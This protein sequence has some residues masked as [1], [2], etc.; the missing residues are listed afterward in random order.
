MK[1]V[2]G[3]GSFGV[4]TYAEY[5]DENSENNINGFYA[6]KSISKADVVD[7]GQISLLC[8]LSYI[9][10]PPPHPNFPPSSLPYPLLTTSPAKFSCCIF[11]TPIVFPYFLSNIIFPTLPSHS[12]QLR[13]VIDE[14]K[15]LAVMNSRFVL[16]LYGKTLTHTHTRT[17]K[18][19]HLHTYTYTHKFYSNLFRL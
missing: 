9:S 7:T 10:P 13:H 15:L 12:G 2:L 4:V 18:C 6:L 19:T 3:S 1:Y 11:S 17:H 14:R 16:K 8:S 5:L